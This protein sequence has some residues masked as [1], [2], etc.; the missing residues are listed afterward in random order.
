VHRLV[1]L[2]LGAGLG[3]AACTGAEPGSTD[4]QDERVAVLAT[5]SDTEAERFGAV[6]DAFSRRTG[7]Q[8][9]YRSAQH[10]LPQEL[11]ERIARGD[12]PDVAFL[13]QPGLL[14]ELAGQGRLVPLDEETEEAVAAHFSPALAGLASYDGRLYGVWFKAANKS[15]VWYDVALFERL[16]VVPPSDL[17]GLLELSRRV[18]ASGTPAFAVSGGS[19]WTLT[20]WFENLYLRMAGPAAYDALAE[21]RIPWTHLTVVRALERMSTLLAPEHVAG[22]VEGA[23]TTDFAVSVQDV[24]GSPRRAAMVV[25]GDFV[26]G[27]V[28]G[29]TDAALRVDA[30]VFPFPTGPDGRR[31][32]VGGGDVA[33]QLRSTPGAA[34]LLRFLATPEAA[35]IWAA[36][37]GFLSPNLDLD[38]S[39]YPD[40]VTRSVA[41]RLLE[42]GEDFRFDLSDLQPAAF[43]GTDGQGL[44][45]ELHAFLGHRDAELAAA[46]LETAAQATVGSSP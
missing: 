29:S 24:F 31:G 18:T 8:V 16:G 43:G 39:V 13:P 20:D 6:L 23:L 7:A 2:L 4:L 25:E 40:E 34:A 27:V 3:V 14:R 45:G 22:G 26:A 19:A 38:L 12:P 37:G 33:V 1:A 42:A 44:F 30:D 28:T 41:R 36:E 32:V 17:D 46:R 5:W 15:L 10:R 21:R 11:A 35:A 9:D